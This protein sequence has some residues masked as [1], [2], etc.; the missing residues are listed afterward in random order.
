MEQHALDV[1]TRN[2]GGD[3]SE[4]E[5]RASIDTAT[6]KPTNEGEAHGLTTGTEPTASPQVSPVLAIV[7]VSSRSPHKEK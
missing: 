1:G 6:P 4:E 7:G 3:R 5:P 2:I